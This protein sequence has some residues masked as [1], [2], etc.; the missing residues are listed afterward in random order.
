MDVIE[1]IKIKDVNGVLRA[2]ISPQV[3]GVASASMNTIL[4]GECTLEFML[5]ANSDKTQ[6]LTPECTIWVG[7]KVFNL[8]KEDSV[9]TVR[10]ENNT[11]WTK[12]MAEERWNELDTKFPVPYITNTVD[13]PVDLT[14]TI[15]SGGSDLSSGKFVVG[16]AGHALFGILESTSSGW[17]VGTVDDT[18]TLHD[19]EMDKAS[20]LSCVKQVQDAWGGFLVWDSENKTV[21]LRTA[22]AWQV[23]AGFQIQYKKNIKG[24]T[25]TQSSRLITRLYPFGHDDLDIGSVNGGVKYINDTSYTSSVYIGIY[26]NQDIYDATELKNVATAELSFICRPRYIYKVNTLDLRTLSDYSHEDFDVGDMVDIIDATVVGT[27]VRPRVLSHQYNI[28][29]PWECSIE[30]GDPEERLQELLKNSINTSSF[31]G[32]IFNSTGQTSGFYTEDGTLSAAKI[33]TGSL[34]VGTN[35]GIG[36]AQDSSGVTTIIGNTVTTGYVNA[37]NITADSV[38]SEWVYAGQISADHI[39]AGDFTLVNSMSIGDTASGT[40]KNIIF[41]AGGAS[42]EDSEIYATRDN[43]PSDKYTHLHIRS[44]DISLSSFN[45]PSWGGDDFVVWSEMANYYTET[46]IDNNFYT[47][48]TADTR[49]IQAGTG[50]TKT[51]DYIN[52]TATG[53]IV[54]FTDSTNETILYD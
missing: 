43:F 25:R 33:V 51:I 28:F 47:K 29:K 18:T 42:E 20:L 23:Y 37:L 38:N 9:D 24:I 5:P 21:S 16:T 26:K 34:V 1:Y 50:G 13:T 15:V 39:T 11:L 35:V 3:D 49:F 8:L 46:E 17:T 45:K 27:S 30:L 54:W 36:T 22:A 40:Q 14:L 44:Y 48:S 10:D 12:F 32:G 6:Y 53:L 4:N 2:N 31:V 41:F 52:A 19:I 7:G